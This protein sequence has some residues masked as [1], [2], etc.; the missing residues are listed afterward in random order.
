MNV[1]NFGILCL[2]KLTG[3]SGVAIVTMPLSAIM[4]EKRRSNI[5]PTCVLSMS[6][7]LKTEDGEPDAELTSDVKDI[8]DGKILV[9]IGKI[10]FI[11][12]MYPKQYSPFDL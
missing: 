2:R 4:H 5:I 11:M 8:I 9:I 6:G 10:V 7:N 12:H 3:I 1:I